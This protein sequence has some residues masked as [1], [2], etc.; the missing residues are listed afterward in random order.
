MA[1]P[2]KANTS[3]TTKSSKL[4]TDKAKAKG[5]TSKTPI[6]PKPRII[7]EDDDLDMD[8]GVDEFDSDFDDD[9]FDDDDF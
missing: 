3:K 6:D 7:D 9:D 8:L 5:T 4:S 1:S 2:K